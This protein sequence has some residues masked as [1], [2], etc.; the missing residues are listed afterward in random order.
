MRPHDGLPPLVR[1][2]LDEQDRA[3]QQGQRPALEDYRA[4]LDQL[5]DPGEALLTLIFNECICRR[6]LQ[7]RPLL[8]E[9]VARFPSLRTRL[10]TLWQ[11]EE[12][13]RRVGDCELLS[14]LG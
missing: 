8:G 14:Q 1:D 7:E 5:P 3:W 13:L 11:A 4:R 12:C 9:Y 2:L 10:A 6:H